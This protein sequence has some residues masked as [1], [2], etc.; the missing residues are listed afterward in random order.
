M[1]PPQRAVSSSSISSSSS[2]SS[3]G[4]QSSVDC[5]GMTVSSN[6]THYALKKMDRSKVS[7][8]NA[9]PKY[10]ISNPRTPAISSKHLVQDS[11]RLPTICA[12][13]TTQ[14]KIRT[15]AANVACQHRS[16]VPLPSSR[17]AYS[18]PALAPRAIPQRVTQ[19]TEARS[20][21]SKTVRPP[22]ALNA[23]I[24]T[25]KAYKPLDCPSQASLTNISKRPFPTSQP[26]TARPLVT[27]SQNPVIRPS[28]G[29]PSRFGR[30]GTT[31]RVMPVFSLGGAGGC[32]TAT[33]SRSGLKSPRR[34]FVARPLT[35]N[36]CGTP[37]G[38][39][40]MKLGSPR[41]TIGTPS[42]SR[43][44][45][46]ARFGSNATSSH[47]THDIAMIEPSSSSGPPA[48]AIL[49]EYGSQQPVQLGSTGPQHGS[50]QDQDDVSFQLAAA[51]STDQNS[52]S[53]SHQPAPMMPTRSSDNDV[54][55]K[56]TLSSSSS[57]QVE[58]PSS[59]QPKQMT[60]PAQSTNQ[61]GKQ[62]GGSA[63]SIV[64][65][66]SE[67]E[68]KATTQYNTIHNQVYLCAIDRLIVRKPGP[69]PPSPSSKIPTTADRDKAERKA[70]RGER[71]KR[72]S[73]SSD[74][75]SDRD[76]SDG[77]ENL[78]MERV[79]HARGPGEDEDYATPVRPGKKLKMAHEQSERPKK[80]VT[81][82][83]GLVVVRHR[84]GE[85]VSRPR[86]RDSS[87]EDAAL[88]KGCLRD[89][90]KVELDPLGNVVE[91]ARPQEKLKRTRIVVAAVFYDGEEPVP[92]PGTIATS[93]GKGRKK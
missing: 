60:R 28:L 39:R 88:S 81:W 90:G 31:T 89:E 58:K 40:L 14:P 86:L 75:D 92:P 41:R 76:E 16:A 34:P 25:V 18:R 77:G 9:C 78:V 7:H 6:G 45:Q 66:M 50:S 93:G 42:Q 37:S 32:E 24:P 55:G 10:P 59:V 62:A 35:N 22:L 71:A 91:S 4:Q 30:E 3:L 19:I 8:L 54:E 36:T 57:E 5:K 51:K 56:E 43:M 64:T 48:S 83:K 1:G 13:V 11:N 44:M 21:P 67:K 85:G 61:R 53:V 27:A 72:R 12:G 74:G 23:S 63:A 49:Y 17:A 38:L 29:F 20:N 2:T 79:S 87:V 70:G 26:V 65:D 84:E 15:A 69:R 80:S 52:S 47:M 33:P 73:R 46:R 82:D 68:L